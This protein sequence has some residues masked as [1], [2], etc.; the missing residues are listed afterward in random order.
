MNSHRSSPTNRV[1]SLLLAAATASACDSSQA[2]THNE[3][4]GAADEDASVALVVTVEVVEEDLVFKV[5]M[6][7]SVLA[8]E[9]AELYAKVGGYLERM[10]V[11][12]GDEVEQGQLLAVISIPEML[13][14]LRR[15]AAEVELARTKVGQQTAAV[16]QARA[17]VVSAEAEARK[18]QS[19][20][21]EKEA[22][23]A[24]RQSELERWKQLLEESPAIERRKLD[25]TRYL[26]EAAEAGLALVDADMVSARA[27]IEEA[28]A[29]VKA[30]QADEMVARARV[31]VAEASHDAIDRAVSPTGC[32][33]AG[34]SLRRRWRGSHSPAILSADRRHHR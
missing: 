34:G 30:A 7:G 20:R 15:H 1:L 29:A 31:P 22:D 2:A 25:E 19:A 8:L 16:A 6:P 4:Q 5:T 33:R 26:L 13:P 17:A 10:E 18:L 23:V 28:K 3:Q 24:L 27:R 21:H 11:D 14:E 12:I 32:A 9:S